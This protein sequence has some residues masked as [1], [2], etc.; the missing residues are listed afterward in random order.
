MNNAPM[1]L[2][3]QIGIAIASLAVASYVLVA[4]HTGIAAIQRRTDN[5][6][7]NISFP[8]VLAIVLACLV[9]PVFLLADRRRKG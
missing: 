4:V 1:T 6:R 5:Y 7:R 8:E 9:W 3:T 2:E